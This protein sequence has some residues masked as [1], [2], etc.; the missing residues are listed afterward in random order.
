MK[1]QWYSEYL[2]LKLWAISKTFNLPTLTIIFCNLGTTTPSPLY[3][4]NEST[5][6]AY[7][8]LFTK[9]NLQYI[10]TIPSINSRLC[11]SVCFI[12]LLWAA[13]IY[14]WKPAV[15]RYSLWYVCMSQRK[16]D[17]LHVVGLTNTNW[18]KDGQLFWFFTLLGLHC[19]SVTKKTEQ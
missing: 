6:K 9:K 11:P 17:G 2:F 8:K 3:K 14:F 13:Q 12:Q 15:L 10:L 7:A 18:H 1:L 5:T 19:S 4:L 16:T